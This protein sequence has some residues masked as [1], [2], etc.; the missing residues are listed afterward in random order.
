M[1]AASRQKILVILMLY[2]HQQKERSAENPACLK[3]KQHFAAP[4]RAVTNHV[5]DVLTKLVDAWWR[6]K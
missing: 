1:A 3:V 5:N 4:G 6:R 2:T